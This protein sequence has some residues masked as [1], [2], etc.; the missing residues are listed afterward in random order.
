MKLQKLVYYSQAWHLVWDEKLLFEE[1]I[2]AWANGPV[3][4]EL[5]DVHRGSFRVVPPWPK[6][7]P[8]LSKDERETIDAVL[9]S[10]GHLDGRRLSA[11]THA[12]A[13][14]VNA[15]GDL[16]ATARSNRP[17]D[18]DLMQEYY[19]ALDRDDEARPIDE[20]TW[21]D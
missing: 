7:G 16:S 17:I 11:L 14:W 13:P 19:S 12:E 5:F 20:I 15:R 3:V 6:R 2:Q 9:G 8:G 4:Y 18:T 1:E 21:D 10:Y